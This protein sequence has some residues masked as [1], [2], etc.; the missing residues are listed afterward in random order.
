MTRTR[1]A[2]SALAVGT[3]LTGAACSAIVQERPPKP[4]ASRAASSPAGAASSSPSPAAPPALTD[5]QA[6]AALITEADLGDPWA[7]SQGAATWRDGFLKARAAQGAAPDCQRLLDALYSDELLAAPARAVIG[8]DDLADGAQLRYQ[9]TEQRPAA[10]DRSLEWMRTL[11]KRCAAFSATT[12]GGTRQ[13]VEVADAPLPEVGDARQG[14]RVTVLAE[15]GEEEYALT[16]DV[17]AVRVGEDAFTLTNG[18]LGDVW[19]EVTAA[20]TELGAQR[21]TEVRRQGR[22]QV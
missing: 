5:A 8:L 10:V 11:P 19:P 18:G 1:L 16:L 13:Q 17:V 20:A 2:V 15:H 21:L 9:V 4:S 6:Q 22:V 3:L 12:A 14:L 7:P